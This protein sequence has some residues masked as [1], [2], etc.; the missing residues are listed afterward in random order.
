[1][2]NIFFLSLL[3]TFI[4]LLKETDANVP[5]FVVAADGSGDFSSI[6]AAI[7]QIPV[8]RDRQYIIYIKK[9][10]YNEKIFIDKSRITLIG[11]NRDSTIIVFA[12][13]RSNWRESH[14][15]DYGSAVINIKNNITDLILISLTVHNNYG[16]LYRNNDHQFAIRG[17]EGVT[18]IIFDNCSI[19]A[20]GGD[21]V[22]LWNTKDGMY[23]HRNCYFEG[24]VDF[25]CPRGYCFIEESKFVGH[26]LS[27]SI[28]HDGSGGKDRK[29]VIK[30]SRFD[31]VPGFALGR[32]HR[33]AQFFLIE[34]TFSKNMAD[35]D[36]YF[37]PSN[38]PR[39]LSWGEDRNYFYNCH[40]DSIDYQWHVDNLNQLEESPEPSD[41]TPLWTFKNLWDP[42]SVLELYYKNQ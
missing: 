25:V 16:S 32:Y 26:N 38:P 12:E 28:W 22:S 7:N 15:D 41:I 23:Y 1:L 2:K 18:R 20:D 9:G 8:S 19:I 17:G 21:T 39:I 29:F 5:D 34:C 4:S 11:E 35:K 36:I 42:V 30:N 3:I 24:Y 14:P 40:G 27:A 37:V 31:G 6:Q 13:L 10:T 33:D